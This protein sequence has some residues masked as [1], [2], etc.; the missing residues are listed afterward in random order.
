MILLFAYGVY[1]AFPLFPLLI[2]AALPKEFSKFLGLLQKMG[3][4]ILGVEQ[5]GMLEGNA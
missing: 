5:D 4:G 2:A 1:I 3:V